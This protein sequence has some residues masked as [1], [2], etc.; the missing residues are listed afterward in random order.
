M[1][2]V[3]D[4]NALPSVRVN[5]PDSVSKILK[6]VPGNDKCSDCGASDPDWASLNLGM[7]IC[8]ECLGIHRNLGVH[9][10]KVRSILLDVR[11]WEPTILDLF[12]TLGNS[13][14]N[15]MWEELLQLPSDGLTNVDAIQSASKPSPKDA[16]HEKEKY[17]LAKVVT[18]E[19]LVS[20][21]SNLIPSRRASEFSICIGLP[22]WLIR[23]HGLVVNLSR[24]NGRDKIRREM[25]VIKFEGSPQVNL[26]SLKWMMK[27]F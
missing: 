10:S 20:F 16:F 26:I 2:S 23:N 6:E 19:T 9:I 22:D 5:Q 21:L 14:C 17:I 13:Y 18:A 27:S 25:E 11:V 8:I 12:R 7:L 3:N 15:S 1:R 24:K 4:E